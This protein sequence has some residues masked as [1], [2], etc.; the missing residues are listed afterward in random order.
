MEHIRPP[1]LSDQ[2]ELQSLYPLGNSYRNVPDR[3]SHSAIKAVAREF[4]ANVDRVRDLGF[5]LPFLVEWSAT[6]QF[7][8]QRACVEVTG[9]IVIDFASLSPE[10]QAAI[11]GK[12]QQY[13]AEF[14]ALAVLI[15]EEYTTQMFRAGVQR[16]NEMMLPTGNQPTPFMARGLD[17]LLSSL[18]FGLW[19]ACE[20]CLTDLWIAA[21]NE[22]PKRLVENVI[23]IPA[24]RSDTD[25]T[26]S[27]A[28]QIPISALADFGYDLSAK[29]GDLLRTTKKVDFQSLRNT[30]RA[31]VSAFRSGAEAL[32]NEADQSYANVMIL[33]AVRNV[34]LHRGG[35]VDREYKSIVGKA[36]GNS[37]PSVTQLSEGDTV[38]VRGGMVKEMHSAVV[39]LCTNVLLFVDQEVHT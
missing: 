19:T 12:V 23:K 10:V 8:N 11:R 30:Q 18:V 24:L 9:G 31:Y 7:H 2:F 36:K 22:G 14:N 26:A 3:L 5:L 25:L 6:D 29:M 20:V 16:L 35:K 21:L 4:A 34:L 33:S 27:Q 1:N 13:E 15:R 38:K 17:S 39:H 37:I 28:K 32:L